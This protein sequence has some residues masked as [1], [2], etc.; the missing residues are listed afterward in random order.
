MKD[1]DMLTAVLKSAKMSVYV[2]CKQQQR[3][4]KIYE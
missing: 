3:I 1:S 2:Y 4:V